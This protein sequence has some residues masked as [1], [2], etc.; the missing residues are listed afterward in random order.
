MT[1]FP[2]LSTRPPLLPWDI[3]PQK[4]RV[5]KTRA[6]I[7]GVGGVGIPRSDLSLL[8]FK[9]SNLKVSKGPGQ[10]SPTIKTRYLKPS[11]NTPKTI[12]QRGSPTRGPDHLSGALFGLHVEC[13]SYQVLGAGGLG[14][15]RSN[16]SLLLLKGAPNLKT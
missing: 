12:L 7:L 15:A 1:S 3:R 4:I 5:L 14:I 10:E 8:L 9:A 6:N 16:L 13:P 11:K 2:G